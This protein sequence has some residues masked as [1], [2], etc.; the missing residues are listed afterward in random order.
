MAKVSI[1]I[2]THNYARFLGEAIQ[3]VLDQTYRDFELIVVDDGSIDNTGEVVSSFADDRIRYMYQ[4]HVGVSAAQNMALHAA[5]G[6][7]I[8][9]LSADDLYLPENIGRKVE[10]LDSRPDIGLVCSDTYIFDHYTGA[11]IG[12]LWHDPKRPNSCFDPVKATLNPLREFIQWGFFIMLQ[13]T[14]VRRR[15]FETVGYFDE[16]LPTHE[17][18]E[19]IIRVLQHF[20][21]EII[22]TPLLKLRRHKSNVSINEEQM[23]IGAI[24]AVKKA[25]RRGS[26][27]REEVKLLK[28]TLSPQHSRFGRWAILNGKGTA[29]RKALLKGIKFAPLNIQLYKYFLLSLLGTKNVRILRNW[30]RRLTRRHVQRGLSRKGYLPATRE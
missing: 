7:Y 17:D 12:R 8:T 4:D 13:A 21:I 14:M 16:S 10:L 30:K 2:P 19:F 22:D 3:S 11:T 23:Y 24:A 25:I 5:T 6:E 28:E 18:W 15:V 27:S 20:S 29:A 9:G 26:F 1:I